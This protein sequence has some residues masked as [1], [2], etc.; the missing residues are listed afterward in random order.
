MAIIE[1]R[2]EYTTGVRALDEQHRQLVEIFNSLE[3]AVLMDRGAR[4]VDA[5]L[6]DLIGYT[7]EHVGF[8]EQVLSDAG[9]G[10][11][12][13]RQRRN[14]EWIRALERFHHEHL[15]GGQV[16]SLAFRRGLREWLAAHLAQAAATRRTVPS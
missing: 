13:E 14:R 10:D 12:K 16:P 4:A 7:Q 2:D 9:C 3:D 6:K 1:W 5:I 15:T 11:L 8:E